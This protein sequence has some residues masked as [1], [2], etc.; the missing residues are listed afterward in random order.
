MEVDLYLQ[1][2]NTGDLNNINDE[3]RELI[4]IKFWT[5]LGKITERYTMGDSTSITVEIA[6]ELL[7][8]ICFLL[9]REIRN[10]KNKI[11]ILMNKDLEV[12]LK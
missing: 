12:L 6:E 8:S 7:E 4:V 5:L 9:K 2:L 1:L 10:C 3:E 11:E